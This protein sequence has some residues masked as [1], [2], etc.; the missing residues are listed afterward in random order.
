MN[1]LIIEVAD[2]NCDNWRVLES[3]EFEGPK[4]PSI[5]AI[6]KKH[7]IK[8]DPFWEHYGDYTYEDGELDCHCRYCILDKDGNQYDG[9]DFDLVY[10]SDP[11]LYDDNNEL[12]LWEMK[13]VL[14]NSYDISKEILD[15]MS[16]EEVIDLF[17]KKCN[18]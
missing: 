14:H 5:K 17:Y 16:E 3:I 11:V 12:D 1:K 6:L 4:P 2:D 9:M 13:L 18:N 8:G 7:G 15:K 10:D